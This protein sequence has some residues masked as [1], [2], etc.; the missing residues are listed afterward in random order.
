M[1]QCEAVVYSVLEGGNRQSLSS[2]I[3]S[4]PLSFSVC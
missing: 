2:F 1:E 3:F 4:F